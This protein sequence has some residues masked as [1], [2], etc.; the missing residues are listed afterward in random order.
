MIVGVNVRDNRTREQ[1]R[2]KKGV[3]V[4]KKGVLVNRCR[5][6]R[7]GVVAVLP[8]KKAFWRAFFIFGENFSTARYGALGCS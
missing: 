2:H 6:E 1:K 8:S 7:T 3:L 4:C 5:L